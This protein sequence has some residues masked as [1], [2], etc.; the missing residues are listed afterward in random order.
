MVEIVRPCI[1][2]A[3]AVV[4]RKEVGRSIIG[5][6]VD[7]R[8]G[9]GGKSTIDNERNRGFLDL[10]VCTFWTIDVDVAVAAVAE[11]TLNVHF[12]IDF[13]RSFEQGA[14]ALNGLT[15]D[16]VGC[17]RQA[18]RL[19]VFKDNAAS[20]EEPDGQ[21]APR[22]FIGICKASQKGFAGCIPYKQLTAFGTSNVEK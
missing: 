6:V 21:A 17:L 18:L 1:G 22:F 15:D 12:F 3:Q 20:V 4:G 11:R 10:P 8:A 2:I 14:V 9:A 13:C 19:P 7:H 16:Q 5:G